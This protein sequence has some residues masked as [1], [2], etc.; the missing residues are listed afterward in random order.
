MDE[1]TKKIRATRQRLAGLKQD[2]RQL[3]V[4]TE[5]DVSAYIKTRKRAEDA[6]AVQA[7]H[8]ISCSA[9]KVNPDLMCQASFGYD[10]TEPP[11][12]PRCGDDAMVYKGAE[13]PKPCTSPEETRTLT[14]AGA[15]LPVGTAS[16]AMRT[17]FPRPF[18]F[19]SLSE[20]TK[21]RTNRTNNQLA[22][23]CSWRVVPAKSR[24]TLVFDPG[25]CTRL[26]G[27]PFLNERH[28]LRIGWA[29]MDAAVVAEAGV[30]LARVE[31]LRHF[32]E[33]TGDS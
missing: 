17:I 26:R 6:A 30:F 13:A 21:K 28:A 8:G 20:E 7:N 14:A 23:F 10:S 24:Q 16:T 11:A 3:L 12:L 15:S 9:Q 25:S 22:P 33:R 29:R 4:A 31:V 19:W 1:L 2:A 5:V 18:L 27:L 32:Q